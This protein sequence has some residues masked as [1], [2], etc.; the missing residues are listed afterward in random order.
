MK[1]ITT[2]SSRLFTSVKTL[3]LIASL[4]FAGAATAQHASN[5]TRIE[6]EN[7]R[8]LFAKHFQNA[9]GS[10]EAVISAGPVHY[11]KSGSFHDINT[12]I[13][14]GTM[15]DFPYANLE[16]LMQSHFGATAHKGIVNVIN[17]VAF[18]EFTNTKMFWE[19][20]GAV[21]NVIASQNVAPTVVGNKA[22]YA[23]MYP[24]IAAE[25]KV[26]N[27][28]RKLN[29][30]IPSANALAAA[31]AG[32]THLVFAEDITL[33]NKW[34]AETK[35]NGIFILDEKG[36]AVALYNNPYST[37][38]TNKVGRSTNT[39]FE[40]VTNGN[41][42]TVLTKVAT[43]WL[44][45]AARQFPIM[46]DPT[47]TAYPLN[48]AGKTALL[49]ADG[50]RVDD[51]IGF[52]RDEDFNGQAD[53]IAGFANFNTASVPDDAI[54][55][56][57]ITVK[58]TLG[59]ADAR[60]TNANGRTLGLTQVNHSNFDED[61]TANNIAIYN[62]IGASGFYGNPM[63]SGFDSLGEK[64]HAINH[65]VARLDLQGLLP[66]DRFV[67]GFEP[68]G[69]YPQD[70]Y[71]LAYGH[72]DAADA[73]NITFTYSLP[74][75][76]VGENTKLIGLYPNPAQDQLNITTDA[77]VTAIEVF[78]LLGQSVAKNVNSNQISVAGLAN[79]MYAV[80]V[81]LDNGTVVNQKFMKN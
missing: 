9:D 44:L 32:A 29:Y 59:V 64:S 45:D 58:F 62:A 26:E 68:I 41:V 76:S 71:C 67:I 81:T 18:A 52:G 46:V 7:K 48:T 42:V 14:A 60:Y 80:Q 2:L 75:A 53:F 49:Y 12:A 57:I 38:A 23:N 34:T 72:S 28:K 22:T 3:I 54:I 33:P 74:V 8:D 61:A 50:F 36:D 47:V 21:Q 13:G 73:P 17:N 24:S 30:I 39:T 65:E 11:E 16:N 15:A 19:T 4:G 78:S 77:T 37:D 55:E 10:I 20:N 1:N 40:V 5:A 56:G 66:T 25:F 79:G 69:S 35:S 6:K 51:L 43:N 70:L 63:T 31:P 27:G